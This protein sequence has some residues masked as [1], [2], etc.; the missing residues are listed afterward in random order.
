VFRFQYLVNFELSLNLPY[1]AAEAL[2]AN[3]LLCILGGV[4]PDILLRGVDDV[5]YAKVKQVV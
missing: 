3:P 2:V 4:N 1:L 5:G